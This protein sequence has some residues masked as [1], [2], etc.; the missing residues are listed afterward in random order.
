LGIFATGSIKGLRLGEA[1]AGNTFE[2]LIIAAT[3]DGQKIE[4]PT[5]QGNT[6]GVSKAVGHPSS[7]LAGHDGFGLMLSDVEGATVGGAGAGQGNSMPGALLSLAL[8]GSHLNHDTI[9]HNTIGTAPPTPFKGFLEFPEDYDTV[10]GIFSTNIFHGG[11]SAGQALR[12][13]ENT[14]QGTMIGMDTENVKGLQVFANTLENNALALVDSGSGGGEID[15][16]SFFND[17]FGVLESSEDPSETELKQASV[18]PEDTKSTTKEGF[19][20]LPDEEYAY[21]AVDA[22]ST[23]ELGPQ[24]ANTSAEPGTENSFLG[25]RFGADASGTAHPDDLP[26]LIGGYEQGLRFGG[27]APGEGNVVEDNRDG[28]VLISGKGSHPAT[29]Q[30]LGNTIY[31]NENFTS[32]IPL[33]GLGIN[34]MDEEGIGA[35]ALGVDPQ[36]PEQPAGGA[37]HS[38]NSPVLDAATAEAGTLTL[39]LSGSLHGVANTN[40]LVEVFADEAA[41]PFG[42]GEGQTLLGR[43][44][45]TTNGEGNVAFTS[46]FTDPGASYRYISST[47]T[48]VP[49]G[50]EPGVTSEFSVDAPIT[51]P[52]AASP[53]APTTTTST[54][55]TTTTTTTATATSK[56]AATTTVSASSSSTTT[57]G[58]SVTLPAKASCSSA[59]STPCTVTTSATIPAAATGRASVSAYVSGAGAAKA[60]RPLTIGHGSMALS[61]GASAPI[62][63]TLTR[64]G[65]ALLRSHHTLS[66]TVTV[67]ISGH[68]RATITRTLHFKLKYKKP[69]KRR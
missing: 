16:N 12:I 20:N 31:N 65:L 46:T 57:A 37:N 32:V 3:L 67:K 18:N 24:S 52:G 25:N 21:E 36:D 19:L 69:A 45:L 2:D 41:N 10:I 63:L 14:I 61:A 15:R 8:L 53:P 39:T 66:I 58:A 51:R 4:A 5:V 22:E 9:S 42:A 26:V 55:T 35:G 49:G 50:G 56:G 38:Q 1:G 54:T 17:G 60:K 40:Y 44:T 47:A 30:V 62:H 59:T 11:K 64:Q 23:A 43:L 13:E 48:T 33:P 6:F 29:V 27:T 7:T 28:G 68:G 34:L